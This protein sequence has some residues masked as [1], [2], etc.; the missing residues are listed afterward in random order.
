MYTPD[1]V[2]VIV[3]VCVE[4]PPPVCWLPYTCGDVVNVSVPWPYLLITGSPTAVDS[5]AYE[6]RMSAGVAWVGSASG[7]KPFSAS[8]GLRCQK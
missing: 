2:P 6:V 8:L 4:Y 5:V 3:V 7:A 1:V